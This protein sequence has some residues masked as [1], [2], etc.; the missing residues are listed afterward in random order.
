LQL[1][2]RTLGFTQIVDLA[3]KQEKLWQ[4]TVLAMLLTTADF[5]TREDRLQLLKTKYARQDSNLRPP[6]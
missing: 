1:G 3:N 2:S 5:L 6:A 4:T